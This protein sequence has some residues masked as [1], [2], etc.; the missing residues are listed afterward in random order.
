MAKSKEKMDVKNT[1]SKK[2]QSFFIK[3]YLFGYNF[4]QVLG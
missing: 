2:Q 4:I 1:A 3:T